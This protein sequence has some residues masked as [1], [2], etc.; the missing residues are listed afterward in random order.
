MSRT[1]PIALRLPPEILSDIETIAAASERTRSWLI[2]R[3]LKLY[4]AG[5]GG[6]L[7]GGPSWARGG[8]RR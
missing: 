4:L 5:E 1:D 8:G 7:P 6:R 3:A 2:V